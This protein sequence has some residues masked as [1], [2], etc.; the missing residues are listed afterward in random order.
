MEPGAIQTGQSLGAQASEKPEIPPNQLD[1]SL[2]NELSQSSDN[3]KLGSP[4]QDT[5]L[6]LSQTVD[7]SNTES[8]KKKDNGGYGYYVVRRYQTISNAWPLLRSLIN[9]FSY[10]NYGDM[11]LPSTSPYEYVAFS[12]PVV[13]E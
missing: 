13:L 7:K 4:H 11:P 9:V 6:D 12:L 10:R 8:D 5:T 3:E 2:D 1:Q